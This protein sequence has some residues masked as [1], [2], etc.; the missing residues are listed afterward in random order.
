MFLTDL[1]F[2]QRTQK[3]FYRVLSQHAWIS[4]TAQLSWKAVDWLQVM[5]NSS[6]QA[7]NRSQHTILFT[8]D[9]GVF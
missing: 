1:R 3:L 4:V 6:C 5:Q 2:E 9:A 7:F 8:L